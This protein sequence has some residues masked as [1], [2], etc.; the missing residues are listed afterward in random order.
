M[1][2]RLRHTL[3]G[4]TVALVLGLTASAVPRRARHDG[5]VRTGLN[6]PI[7]VNADS[8]L[9]VQPGSTS[10]KLTVNTV[11]LNELLATQGVPLTF[12]SLV[13]SSNNPGN[14][15]YGVIDQAGTA[16]LAAGS[17]S[18]S[19]TI[20][21]FQTDYVLPIGSTGMLSLSGTNTCT[22]TALGDSAI[23]QSWFDPTNT[24]SVAPPSTPTPQVPLVSPDLNSPLGTTGPVKF[25]AGPPTLILSVIPP[26]ALINEISISM[27]AAPGVSPTDTFVD[28]TVLTATAVPEPTSLVLI[29]MNL[30]VVMGL[31]C[32]HWVAKAPA[33]G[34]PAE[35][36]RI[37]TPA[38]SR[39]ACRETTTGR[40][41]GHVLARCNAAV[42]PCRIRPRFS[43]RPRYHCDS[44]RN[45]IGNR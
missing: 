38:I 12:S 42:E 34:R 13:A 40:K 37:A 5:P 6:G 27:T 20:E 29:L 22:D 32:H 2:R 39:W 28:P 10:D 11:L 43:P 36:M 44:R 35:R 3:T 30:P 8:P 9:A 21:T 15:S 4:V 16:S 17:G 14:L 1:P 7:V 31:L 26:Y 19:F 23:F 33:P 45:A 41:Q 25:S 18:L 24:A